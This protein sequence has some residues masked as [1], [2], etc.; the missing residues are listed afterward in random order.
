[1][2]HLRENITEGFCLNSPLVLLLHL[3]VLWRQLL[4]VPFSPAPIL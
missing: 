2:F 4:E 1:M 3:E